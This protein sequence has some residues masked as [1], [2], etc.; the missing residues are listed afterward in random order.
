MVKEEKGELSHSPGHTV[1]RGSPSSGHRLEL[2]GLNRERL[3]GGMKSVIGIK[4]SWSIDGRP[5]C[6]LSA[7]FGSGSGEVVMLS[8]L[9]RSSV[10]RTGCSFPGGASFALLEKMLSR[11]PS[12]FFLDSKVAAERMAQ[13][14]DRYKTDRDSKLFSALR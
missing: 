11:L 3:W 8:S 10:V 12:L 13:R 2:L 5:D 9:D 4:Q 7:G 1:G 14:K 6:Y